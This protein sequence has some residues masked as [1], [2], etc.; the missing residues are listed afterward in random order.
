MEHLLELALETLRANKQHNRRNTDD[1]ITCLRI[2]PV[3]GH[4]SFPALHTP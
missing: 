2:V 1:W 3:G 4:S